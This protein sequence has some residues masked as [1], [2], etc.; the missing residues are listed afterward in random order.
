MIAKEYYKSYQADD[1]LSDLSKQLLW[2][3]EKENPNH[4]FEFGAGTGKHLS[5]LNQKGIC[6]IGLDISFLNCIT[7]IS[8]HELPF[9]MR[10]DETHL[11]HICNADIVFTCSVLDH[12]PEVGGII[13]EFKRI[14]N[15]TVFLCETQDEVGQYYYSHDYISFGF[16][17]LCFSWKSN[18]NEAIYKI[19]TFR[20]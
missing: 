19:W 11:R 2:L 7:A 5:Y 3:I 15:K 14:A 16:D 1:N 9:I 4:V 18:D 6:T 8:R 12:I 17:E 13:D 20:K 10:G